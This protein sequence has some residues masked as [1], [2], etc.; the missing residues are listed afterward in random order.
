MG[1]KSKTIS[2][3]KNAGVYFSAVVGAGFASGQE[4][5]QFFTNYGAI[6]LLAI[7]P[8]TLLFGYLGKLFMDLSHELHTNSHSPIIKATC[9]KWLGLFIDW[10]ITFFMFGCFAL[11]ISGGGTTLADYFHINPVLGRV[12]VATVAVVI[13]ILG[14][15][16]ISNFSGLIGPVIIV[17]V[18]VVG[19]IAIIRSTGQI[20]QVA[21]ILKDAEVYRAAPNIGI[22]MLIYV[23]YCITPNIAVLAGIG[24]SEEDQKVRA[25]SGWV[26]GIALGV[27]L[28]VINYALLVNY[29]AIYKNSIPLV[30]LAVCL[31]K[32]LGIYFAIVLVLG[33]LTSAVA[34]LFGTVT[35]FTEYG[36]TKSKLFAVILGILSLLIGLIPFSKLVNTL[37]P[38]LGYV[39]I[40][41]IVGSI[42][43]SWKKK[44]SKS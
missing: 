25:L 35:R 42:W 21:G 16:A 15:N 23:A 3:L 34:F 22:S 32:P 28:L 5:M 29:G 9:G 19:I 30:E 41:V 26:G 8:V 7:I 17:S 18:L 20:N 39:G 13:V 31:Y 12:I 4:V 6:S 37:Y 11:M 27:C 1:K 10:V 2:V 24:N 43:Y 33:I 38:L 14:F 40:V 36:T 44:T